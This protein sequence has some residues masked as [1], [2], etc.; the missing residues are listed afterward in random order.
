[1]L[2][3]LNCEV[4]AMS[5]TQNKQPQVLSLIRQEYLRDYFCAQPP[6]FAYKQQCYVRKLQT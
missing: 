6:T 4:C 2:F 1:M 3:L 5:K